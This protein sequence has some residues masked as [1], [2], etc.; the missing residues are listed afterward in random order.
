MQNVNLLAEFH[1]LM[2]EERVLVNV[3][4][5]LRLYTTLE[6]FS[7]DGETPCSG[8]PNCIMSQS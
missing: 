8:P 1:G 7:R 5:E 3:Q 6:P 2:G 4:R